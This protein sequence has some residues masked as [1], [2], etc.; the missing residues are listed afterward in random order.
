MAQRNKSIETQKK[1]LDAAARII[2]KK[3]YHATT[4]AEICETAGANIAA[5]NYHFGDKEHLYIETWKSAFQHA[6]EA[7]P[8]DGGVAGEADIP[9]RLRG[10]AVS[11]LRRVTDPDCFDFEMT[12][13]EMTHPTGLLA[14]VIRENLDKIFKPLE[15]IV[16]EYLGPDADENDIQLCTMSI[17]A[18]CMNPAIFGLRDDQLFPLP[19]PLTAGLDRI[20]EHVIRFSLGGL[21]QAKLAVLKAASG[22]GQESLLNIRI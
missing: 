7:Y 16:R 8:P 14:D 2:S 21:E 6:I 15:N 13:A 12:H 20:A 1:I 19:A 4:V 10:W 5:V 11:M 3:G 22:D 9:T 18:Q 17:H